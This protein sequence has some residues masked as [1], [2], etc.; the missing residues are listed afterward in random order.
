[1][2]NHGYQILWMVPLNLAGVLMDPV[3]QW[4][5]DSSCALENFRWLYDYND[6]LYPTTNFYHQPRR[7]QL[8]VIVVPLLLGQYSPFDIHLRW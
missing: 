1:M 2:P 3:E 5:V 4:K 6:N 7:W 8:C